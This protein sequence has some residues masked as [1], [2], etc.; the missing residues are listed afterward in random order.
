MAAAADEDDGERTRKRRKV[1]H[2]R[3][4]MNPR[5]ENRPERSLFQDLTSRIDDMDETSYMENFRVK[6]PAFKALLSSIQDR[7]VHPQNHRRPI[8]PAE[9]LGI[10]LK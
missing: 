7:L 4:Y 8:S 10:T 1:G 6:K 5:N 9:R 2:R 3:Y